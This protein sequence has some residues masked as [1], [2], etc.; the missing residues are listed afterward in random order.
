MIFSIGGFVNR[1]DIFGVSLLFIQILVDILLILFV[2]VF[3]FWDYFWKDASKTNIN[4]NQHN[5]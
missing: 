1:V 5:K 4:K 3:L 2:C